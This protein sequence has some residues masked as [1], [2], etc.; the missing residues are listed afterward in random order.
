MVIVV[1]DGSGNDCDFCLRIDDKYKDRIKEIGELAVAGLSAWYSVSNDVISEED[2]KY[3]S[4]E[5]IRNFYYLGYAE[6]SQILLSKHG[7]ES[8]IE[9][10]MYDRHRHVICDYLFNY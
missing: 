8:K 2:K 1:A 3:F 9:E 5:E 10:M 4:E 6:P 7:I